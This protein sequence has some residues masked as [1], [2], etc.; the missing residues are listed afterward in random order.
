MAQATAAM[1]AETQR[2]AEATQEQAQATQE[3]VVLA[4]QQQL[5]AAFPV[6]AFTLVREENWAAVQH[7]VVSVANTGCG[8]ALDLTISRPT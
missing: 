8:P 4:R 3:M 7:L 5:A 2:Q 6:I 1:A